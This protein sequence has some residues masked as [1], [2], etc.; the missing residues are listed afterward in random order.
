MTLMELM[1]M[2][3]KIFSLIENLH[4]LC[5]RGNKDYKEALAMV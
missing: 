1:L 4:D 5:C 3:R 2:H